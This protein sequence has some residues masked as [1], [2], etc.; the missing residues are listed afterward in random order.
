MVEA[1]IK[2]VFAFG[3]TVEDVVAAS[4]IDGDFGSVKTARSRV[5]GLNVSAGAQ[6]KTECKQQS[7]RLE[8]SHGYIILIN[9]IEK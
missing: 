9:L 4:D 8:K 1:R 6:Y 2:A 5:I 3:I 7:N